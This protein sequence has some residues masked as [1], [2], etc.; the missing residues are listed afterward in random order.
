MKDGR[1]AALTAHVSVGDRIADIGTDHARLPIR[2][3]HCKRVRHA[4]LTDINEGP[5]ARA[6]ANILRAYGHARVETGGGETRVHTEDGVC[7]L[8]LGDGLAPLG[9]DEANVAV[10]AGMGGEMIV[11]I[12][13]ADPVKTGRVER[14]V[15]QPRTK[16]DALRRFIRARRYRVTDED[17]VA[18]RGRIC[19]IIV[20]SPDTRDGDV[21]ERENDDLPE[22][23]QIRI[24]RAKNHPLLERFLAERIERARRVADEAAKGAGEAA[25]RRARSA[26]ARAEAL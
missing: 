19:E 20:M 9:P 7:I 1:I 3:L 6:R 16:A 22:A 18:E 10:I 8:R 25:A 24:L 13:D 5:L 14:Y 17:L 21:D 4:I 23:G 2:L 12:L 11:R 15:L 26:I